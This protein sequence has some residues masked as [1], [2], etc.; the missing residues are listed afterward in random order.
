MFDAAQPVTVFRCVT[1]TPALAGLVTLLVGCG[2]SPE[3]VAPLRLSPCAEVAA[4]AECGTL[5]V[6]ENRAI[7]QGRQI[8][9][10]VVVFRA[11]ERSARSGLFIFAGGPGQASTTFVGAVNGWLQPV[12][13]TL[14]VVLVDQRGTGGSHA[15]AC[16]PKA[17]PAMVFGHVF[18]PDVVR[19]CRETLAASADLSKYTTAIAVEDVDDVRA[20]LGYDRVSLFGV[21]YGTRMAQ[22]YA[23]RF[24]ER[25]RSIVLDGVV[26]FDVE[27]PQSYAAGAQHALD[28]VIAACRARPDCHAAHPSL[29]QQ[30][31][32]ILA[33]LGGNPVTATVMSPGGGRTTVVMSLGDFGYAVRG[34]LYAPRAVIE[35]PEMID[36]AA[37]GG[38]LSEF[39]QRYWDRALRLDRE[40]ALGHHFSVLCAED[41]AFVEDSTVAAAVEH[42][43]LGRYVLDDYRRACDLWA[44]PPV[45]RAARTP[46][47][48]AA[49]TLLISGQFDPVTPP[50]FANAVARHLS[51]ARQLL[52]PTGAHGSA[53]GCP[54]TAVL[55]VLTLGTLEGLPT[56]CKP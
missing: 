52:A 41:V 27:L 7:G 21:S 12:R 4:D 53:A 33:R 23:R 55:H 48:S 31:E 38:D 54:R 29:A 35:L 17:D 50:E 18:R 42:T 56:V 37:T 9:I 26:P 10:K 16:E 19:R 49:P 15:L 34:I 36:R 6:F 11:A 24:P 14:D 45:D 22:A 13:Q 3:T 1:R 43:F 47:Q 30:F 2:R 40:L 39:A 46:L 51:N 32:T 5:T 44:V 20:A 25:T 8:P 28:K